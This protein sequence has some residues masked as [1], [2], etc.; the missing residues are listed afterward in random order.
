MV[1]G[2]IREL[3]VRF[4]LMVAAVDRAILSG[5]VIHM[6]DW[7]ELETLMARWGL[8]AEINSTNIPKVGVALEKELRMFLRQV[9]VPT[10]V[11]DWMTAMRADLAP[12]EKPVLLLWLKYPGPTGT[13]PAGKHHCQFTPT[14]IKAGK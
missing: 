12:A 13:V 4:L 14:A 1:L 3:M 7:A 9:G 5:H 10:N 8:G 2:G 6:V 11:R